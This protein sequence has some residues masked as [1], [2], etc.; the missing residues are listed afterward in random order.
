MGGR[1]APFLLSNQVAA[2]GC[3]VALRPR[4]LGVGAGAAGI[5]SGAAANISS[6]AMGINSRGSGAGT[7]TTAGRHCSIAWRPAHGRCVV[8]WAHWARM[9]TMATA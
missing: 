6:G 2:F 9:I 7:G 8:K 4:F 1:M 5:G 3:L